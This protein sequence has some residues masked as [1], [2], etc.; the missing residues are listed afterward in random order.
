[1]QTFNLRQV[2][3]VGGGPAGAAAA[4][5][6]TQEGCPVE[7]FER[8]KQPHHKVCGE[9]IS[10]GGRQCLEDLRVWNKFAALAPCPIRRCKLHFGEYIK[11][12]NLP[13]CAWGLSRLQLDELL[14]NEAAHRG[15][16][17]RRGEVFENRR[18]DLSKA[19]IIACG[20]N[21]RAKRGDRLFGFKAHF[22]GDADDAVEL[23]F[24]RKGYIGISG[25]EDQLTNVC[26]VARESTLRGYGFDFDEF[27]RRSPALAERLSPLRS[28]WIGLSPAL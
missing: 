1:M 25:V 2:T 24:D 22:E 14:I 12:W 3:V 8:T 27:I 28:K 16:V 20:R 13:E 26:G 17:I 5:A 11:E 23:F 19:L 4:I 15:A 10:P 6:A 21:S 18:N 9:F 7:L